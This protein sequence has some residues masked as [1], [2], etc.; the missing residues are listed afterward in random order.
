M[1]SD[2]SALIS[3]HLLSSETGT[4]GH[5]QEDMWFWKLTGICGQ[6]MLWW[7]PRV[8][9]PNVRDRS[10][11]QASGGLDEWVQGPASGGTESPYSQAGSGL[12]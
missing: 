3:T 5:D 6:R 8:L 10:P 2:S 7:G 12:E 11:G 9:L 1:I 4:G